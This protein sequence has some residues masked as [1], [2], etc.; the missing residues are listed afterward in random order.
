MRTE[1]RIW[2]AAHGWSGPLGPLGGAQWVLVFGN[3]ERLRR[4]ETFEEIRRAYPKAYVMGCSSAGEIIGTEVK[5]NSLVMTAVHFDR[6]RV[7]GVSDTVQ[8]PKESHTVGER[9]GRRFSAEGLVHVFVLAEGVQIHGAD[10]LAGLVS[11]LP[12]GVRVTGGLAADRGFFRETVVMADG[13]AMTNRVAAVGFYG[14]SLHVAT[15]AHSGWEAFGPERLITRSKDNV[16]FELDGQRALTLYQHSLG[17]QAEKLPAAGLLFPLL[18]RAPARRIG[19]L[20]TVLAVND[21]DHSLTFGG[22]MPR[23]YFT[24]LLKVSFD[25]LIDGAVRA[26]AKVLD[27]LGG[28]SP[29]LAILVSGVGRKMILRHRTEEEILGLHRALGKTTPMAGFHAYAQFAPFEGE[30]GGELHNQTMTM[31]AFSED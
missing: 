3:P 31:T 11:A 13:P 21:G 27:Q 15:G 25:R 10:L 7:Q 20:R 1:Q 4:P 30:T 29:N 14:S 28:S 26:A 18:L 16:L 24:R 5:E 17:D 22:N 12:S 6:T 19:V 23:G 2:T 8:D 9:V